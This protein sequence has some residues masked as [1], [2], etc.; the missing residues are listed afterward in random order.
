M[1]YKQKWYRKGLLIALE[2]VCNKYLQAPCQGFSA[3]MWRHEHDP[4]EPQRSRWPQERDAEGSAPT[5]TRHTHCTSRQLGT[6]ANQ[7]Y[8]VPR[9]WLWDACQMARVHWETCCKQF[10]SKEGPHYHIEQSARNPLEHNQVPRALGELSRS[11]HQTSN[12]H[13]WFMSLEIPW[14]FLAQ[15]VLRWLSVGLCHMRKCQFE[16][17]CEK[18]RFDSRLPSGCFHEK[19]SAKGGTGKENRCLVYYQVPASILLQENAWCVPQLW[20]RM[21][22][23]VLWRTKGMRKRDKKLVSC[24]SK[25][26]TKKLVSSNCAKILKEEI[27]IKIR[28]TC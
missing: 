12:N 9:D 21:Y 22:N 1:I 7:R 16:E 15:A 18:K 10:C 17:F 2:E 6:T 25:K 14:G 23:V 11:C 8:D 20:G 27:A 19:P 3:L 5:H 4:Q 24:A 28:E 26:G 13:P